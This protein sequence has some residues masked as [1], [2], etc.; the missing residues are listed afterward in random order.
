MCFQT[1]LAIAVK[2]I[3]WI[4]KNVVVIAIGAIAT[5]AF[6][7]YTEK[8]SL[9]YKYYNHVAQFRSLVTP[10]RLA[11]AE[12]FLMTAVE[13]YATDLKKGKAVKKY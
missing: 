7:K 13:R 12:K 1:A 6:C 4:V 2:V 10:E 9:D 11:S 3:G 8:C 5:I